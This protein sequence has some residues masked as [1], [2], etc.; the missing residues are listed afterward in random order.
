MIYPPAALYVRESFN[1]MKTSMKT[2]SAHCDEAEKLLQIS[3]AWLLLVVL[4]PHK[5]RLKYF[6]YFLNLFFSSFSEGRFPFPFPCPLY[7][8]FPP[9]TTN[10]LASRPPPAGQGSVFPF[11]P[12][13]GESVTNTGPTPASQESFHS[14]VVEHLRNLLPSHLLP[15]LFLQILLSRLSSRPGPASPSLLCLDR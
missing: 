5:D 1:E 14:S 10:C 8:F 4:L 11:S 6:S 7:S 3:C 9:W 15:S 2:I 13:C 12:G